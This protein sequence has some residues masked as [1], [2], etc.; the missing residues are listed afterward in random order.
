MSLIG[1]MEMV[2]EVDDDGVISLNLECNSLTADSKFIWS[3]NYE[4]I[5]DSTRLTMETKGSK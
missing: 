3:K 5:K 2:V 4:E 1:T